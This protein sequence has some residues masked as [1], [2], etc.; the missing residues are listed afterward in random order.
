[1]S[2]NSRLFYLREKLM[3]RK[4]KRPC[5]YPG[6]PKLT[7]GQYCEEHK[8]LTDKQYN[9]YERDKTSQRFYQSTE[10]KMVKKRHL[11]IE[12]LCRECKKNGKL[13]KAA[14]VDHILPIKQG[15]AALDDNNLQSLCWSCHS[16]KSVKE[17]SRWGK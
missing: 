5:A 13:T 3:P 7:G 15:G 10:W 4:P 6:C 1:L 14:M 11:A 12:P 9:L 16:R 8:K 17:G 2:K